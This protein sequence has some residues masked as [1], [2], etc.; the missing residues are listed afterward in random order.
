MCVLDKSKK[1]MAMREILGI[2]ST[3]HGKKKVFKS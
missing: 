1:Q 3:L 2:S